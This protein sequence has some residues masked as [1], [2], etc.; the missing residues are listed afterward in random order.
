MQRLAAQQAQAAVGVREDTTA[1]FM[2]AANAAAQAIQ[3]D[4]SETRKLI[5]QQLRQ[6]GWTVDSALLR[7]S[8][9]SRPE[10]G[11]N[12]AIAEWPTASGPADYVFF[13]G[14][15]PIAAVEATR[16][17]NLQ[18]FADI[19]GIKELEEQPPDTDTTVHIAT[20][21]GMVQR[22]L[23]PSEHTTP[24]AVDQYDCIIVDECHRGYP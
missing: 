13:V 19:F 14:L 24:P 2:Y 4:E 15:T 12:L 9:G 20:V 21:Q 1:S 22:A 16:M 18:T 23:Y 5:D 17:E 10:R 8:E 11:K 6:A 7:Y 3:L